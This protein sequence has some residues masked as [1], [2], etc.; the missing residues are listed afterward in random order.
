MPQDH[1][2]HGPAEFGG[3]ELLDLRTE[4]GIAQIELLRDAILTGKETGKL[5]QLSLQ[6]SQRE[7]GS[8]T[9]LLEHPDIPIV[10]LSPTWLMSLRQYL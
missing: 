7:A 6:H 1:I 5:V 10:Y 8:T 9:P 3:L 4:L 2:R